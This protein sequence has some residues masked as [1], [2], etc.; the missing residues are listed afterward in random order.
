ML[1]RKTIINIVNNVLPFLSSMS[2]KTVQLAAFGLSRP[3]GC[4]G[5]NGLSPDAG[6]YLYVNHNKR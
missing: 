1:L 6:G 5:P 3:V 2:G 4:S